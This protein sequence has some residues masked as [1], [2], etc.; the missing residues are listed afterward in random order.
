MAE[1]YRPVLYALS[2]IIAL[3]AQTLFAGPVMPDTKHLLV[4]ALASAWL[5]FGARNRFKEHKRPTGL[6]FGITALM[7]WLFYLQMAFMQGQAGFNAE[8]LP[9][10]YTV[11]NVFRLLFG[12]CAFV[13]MLRMLFRAVSG[14]AS[15][16]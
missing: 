11:Y 14:F 16:E 9:H 12:M 10:I 5:L 15:N 13:G 7:P 2:L 4:M 1:A 8:N 3:W 6:F